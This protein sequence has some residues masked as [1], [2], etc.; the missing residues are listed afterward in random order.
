MKIGWLFIFLIFTYSAFGQADD[1]GKLKFTGYLETYY[2][3]DF[4]QPDD[5]NRPDFLYNF[6]RHNELSFNL[7]MLKVAYESDGIRANLA[8]MAGTYAQ[9]NLAD[10]PTWAQFVNEA[11]LGIKLH[12]KLW[13]D[14]GIMPSHIGFE[15]WIGAEGWHL[16]RSLLAENSPYF[17]TGARL[18][19]ALKDNLDLTLWATNGWQNV[20]R[21]ERSRGIGIGLGINHRP[22]EGLEI[23]YANYFG[24][25]GLDPI[26]LLRFFNNF[27]TQYQIGA[28]GL[29]FGADYGIQEAYFGNPNNW[30]GLTLSLRREV[31]DKF[32]LAGRAE[33]YS[34]PRGI[35]LSRGLEVSGLSCNL[36]YRYNATTL[37]RLE[38]RQF[39]S[40]RGVFSLPGGTFSKGNTAVTASFSLNF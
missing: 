1:K 31:S 36:D 28:W 35:I 5:Q 2:A 25:E 39:I 8:L 33:H 27:Y 20:Q 40:P 30:Y 37:F 4:N 26:R 13:L 22:I 21:A 23:N 18:T 14:V 24:N 10:E 6:S 16:S 38:G 29:T 32:F 34:D 19:Y 3:Y 11:S 15:S 7:A 12:E 9:F 17:L